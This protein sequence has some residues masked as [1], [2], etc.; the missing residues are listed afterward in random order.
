MNIFIDLRKLS[1]NLW[2]K[3]ESVA[4]ISESFQEW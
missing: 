4:Q 1:F 2:I 3:E